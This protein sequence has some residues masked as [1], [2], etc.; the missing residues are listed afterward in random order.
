M[1]LIRKHGEIMP[2]KDEVLQSRIEKKQKTTDTGP[3]KRRVEMT[4]SGKS[5][6]R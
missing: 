6:V 3:R 1:T 2:T 4:D 5:G